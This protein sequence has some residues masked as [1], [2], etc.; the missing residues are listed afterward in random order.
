MRAAAASG[1]V[2]AILRRLT[3][4]NDVK[5]HGFARCAASNRLALFQCSWPSGHVHE[6]FPR[7]PSPALRLSYCVLWRLVA[8]LSDWHCKASA[9][10]VKRT[11]CAHERWKHVAAWP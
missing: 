5:F 1:L 10:S 7:L 8:G 3:I 9:S 2:H 6:H 11:V 4:N